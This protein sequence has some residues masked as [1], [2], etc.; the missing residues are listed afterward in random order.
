MPRLHPARFLQAAFWLFVGAL[1]APEISN[2]QVITNDDATGNESPYHWSISS[3]STDYEPNAAEPT[4]GPDSLYLWLCRA[5]GLGVLPCTPVEGVTS[6]KFG[7]S[8]TGD[9][10]ITGLTPLWGVFNLGSVTCPLFVFPECTGPFLV[11]EISILSLPGSICIVPCDESGND[12]VKGVE[13]CAEPGVYRDMEWTGFDL[14]GGPCGKGFLGCHGHIDSY[15]ACCFPDG[16]CD[17]YNVCQ[18]LEMGGD[19]LGFG[20]DCS[21]ETCEPI[22]TEPTSWGRTKSLY[23]E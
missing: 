10:V 6:A 20:S 16:N 14:G 23:R 13:D 5:R 3:S 12:P 11:A 21:P 1:G 18:C 4:G 19:P 9:V 15:G 17:F 2:A 7:L 8:T 22:S